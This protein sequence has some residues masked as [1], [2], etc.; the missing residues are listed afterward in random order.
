M[1]LWR[2]CPGWEGYYAASTDGDLKSL[3]RL[4]KN[5][6]D[7]GSHLIAG[8]ILTP[9]VNPKDGYLHYS[10][11]KNGKLHTVKGHRMVLLTFVGPCPEG[12][13]GRHLNGDP[14][15][16]HVTNLAWG[17]HL[18]N[19]EDRRQYQLTD[20]RN[21]LLITPNLRPDQGNNRRCIACHRAA[22]KVRR[23]VA[24]S[25]PADFDQIANAY[26]AALMRGWTL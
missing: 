4:V 19:A 7:N 25:K 18:Q 20:K 23:L 15:D 17:T 16:N 13:E 11:Y 8:K 24:A 10:F 5:S 2:D 9:G 22:E 14:A 12:E 21:H 1:T 3:P 26:Y 6:R